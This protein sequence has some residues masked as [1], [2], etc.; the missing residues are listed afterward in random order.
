M[1][2]FNGRFSQQLYNEELYNLY[3]LLQYLNYYDNSNPNS[4][5][6]TDINGALW[7]DGDDLK[8]TAN[9][10]WELLF[11]NRFGLISNMLSPSQP[12]NPIYG[13]FWIDNGTLK[14][15]N[16]SDFVAVKA[17]ITDQATNE[18]GYQNFII[19]NDFQPYGKSFSASGN[20][21]TQ[22]TKNIYFA[23][24]KLDSRSNTYYV[25][26]PFSEYKLANY[27]YS[28]VYEIKDENTK[29][30]Q[31]MSQNEYQFISDELGTI[32]IY[33]SEP[34]D[35]VLN[36][37][38][39][40]VEGAGVTYF[41]SYN[42]KYLVPNSVADKYFINYDFTTDY[43]VNNAVTVSFKEE[44]VYDKNMT[45]VHVDPSYLNDITKYL[46][47]I[48]KTE[49][50]IPVQENKN[51]QYAEYYIFYPDGSSKL[52][53]NDANTENYIPETTGITIND[54]AFNGYD[55]AF[56]LTI[57]YTF[58]AFKTKGE[59][60]RISST[61]ITEGILLD[62]TDIVDTLVFANESF[63]DDYTLKNNYLK[64]NHIDSS[65]NI[66]VIELS[67]QKITIDNSNIP[68][69]AE[70]GQLIFSNA[71]LN[72]AFA[73]TDIVDYNKLLIVIN[74]SF[75][76]IDDLIFN[77]NVSAYYSDIIYSVDIGNVYIIHMDNMIAKSGTIET[78]GTIPC[79]FDDIEANN[80]YY[81]ILNHKIMT[82][83]FIRNTLSGSIY[84]N[85]FAIDDSYILIDTY[86][87]AES[88]LL[89]TGSFDTN[90]ITL[91]A[92]NYHLIYLNGNIVIDKETVNDEK[93]YYDNQIGYDGYDY[94]YQ[95]GDH[96]TRISDELQATLNSLTS[97]YVITGNN[98]TFAESTELNGST[99]TV[100]AYK[101]AT[102]VEQ[103]L[104]VGTIDI[105][106][107]MLT[108]TL[109]IDH[110]YSKGNGSLSI[111]INGIK[112]HPNTYT[113]DNNTTFT[114][115]ES[116]NN[117]LLYVI[118]NVEGNET[119][120]YRLIELK[121]S[122]AG[123]AGTYTVDSIYPGNIRMF[124]NGLRMPADM[125]TVIDP[126]TIT[127]NHLFGQ[128]DHIW[129]E[130]RNDYS[131]REITLPIKY[132]QITWSTN[133][134]VIN[135]GN[136]TGDELPEAIINANDF[137]MV[138]INGLAYGTGYTIDKQQKTITL[139]ESAKDLFDAHNASNGFITFE[140]R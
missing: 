75:Y 80:N 27:I 122:I 55:E 24:W 82:S 57:V 108:Y 38:G 79:S 139:D 125:Y 137:V 94:Y 4:Q 127:I 83:D 36:L 14:Y 46:F 140:W 1:S 106:E 3:E 12:T 8:Y 56:V 25:Q 134:T 47:Y 93:L 111:F 128:N 91:P 2:R 96:F 124:V 22:Y 73:A 98:L 138:Y 31:I 67:K 90:Q 114:L 66:S 95:K 117:K 35:C 62:K 10:K 87:G 11:R 70:T 6:P 54:K 104:T 15:Y 100:M 126:Y 84:S 116:D 135:Y 69:D 99:Y 18:F 118:E 52:L 21:A 130:V 44:D 53:T 112:Q 65:I 92:N 28:L 48:N 20:T 32:S 109:P 107:D 33:V 49:K 63:T 110:Q 105:T 26:V 7:L 120:A 29:A 81:L 17:S 72:S 119:H 77:N 39:T 113:E 102:A 41:E 71:L 121:E 136:M 78:A 30:V 9:N 59:V 132:D 76:T 37:I 133:S 34:I 101:Y 60:Q 45:V 115:S 23:D 123:S 16:G 97:K 40:Y 86:Y 42:T 64:F 85:Q 51:N 13:Q 43:Q 129:L 88:T 19:L 61:I 131:L 68:Y 58:N 89:Y 50:F 103:P 74:N 5:P